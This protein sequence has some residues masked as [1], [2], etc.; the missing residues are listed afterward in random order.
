[1]SEDVKKARAD[2]AKRLREAMK[3]LEDADQTISGLTNSLQVASD[4][5]ISRLRDITLLLQEARQHIKKK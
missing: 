3:A 2:L 4:L 1:M 5:R